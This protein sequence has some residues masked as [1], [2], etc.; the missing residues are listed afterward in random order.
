M[1]TQQHAPHSG[2]NGH[3]WARASLPSLLTCRRGPLPKSHL[4]SGSQCPRSPEYPLWVPL[5][6]S[7]LDPGDTA[8]LVAAAE[9][10]KVTR[11]VTL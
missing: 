1:R 3:P 7:D 10:S 9:K 4:G 11:E 8:D 2:P 6:R 5:P